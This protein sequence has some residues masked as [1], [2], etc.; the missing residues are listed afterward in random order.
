MKQILIVESSPRGVD[1]AS[2]QLTGK[3]R[4]RLRNL[5]PEAKL[6]EQDLAR[7]PLPHLDYPMIKAIFT[8]DRTEAESLKDVLRL[9]DQ[10]TEQLLASDLLVIGSPM[11]NFGLPSSLKAWIDHIVRPGKTFRYAGAGVEGLAQGKKAILVLASGGV[12]TGGPWTSWDTVE[13][14]LRLILGFIGIADVQTVRAQGVN[15][16]ALAPQAVPEGERMIEA[17]A[18]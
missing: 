4:E 9:S 7:D 8:K 6:V 5:Y 15:I 18:L 2:R 11:W 17:L 3:V 12:F 10:L 1:S 13:P 14:Y 16:P